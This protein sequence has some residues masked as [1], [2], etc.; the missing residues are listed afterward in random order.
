MGE[1]SIGASVESRLEIYFCES[2]P[3]PRWRDSGAHIGAP[4]K[5]VET[6]L[7]RGRHMC[8]PTTSP[9]CAEQRCAV[10]K[11]FVRH[12]PSPMRQPEVFQPPE[13]HAG[14]D[15]TK[16]RQRLTPWYHRV[17]I[18]QSYVVLSRCYALTGPELRHLNTMFAGPITG[19]EHAIDSP[20]EHHMVPG[21]PKSVAFFGD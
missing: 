12:I 20:E 17:M 15:Q 18:I 19:E 13:L 9:R 4:L 5:S 2:A 8:V 3:R 14:N 21:A 7:R 6:I 16:P 1:S 11:I 10:S